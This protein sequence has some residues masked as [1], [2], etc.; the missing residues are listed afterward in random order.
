MINCN[1][2]VQSAI[3]Y[4]SPSGVIR[5]GEKVRVKMEFMFRAEYI[6]KG[7]LFIFREGCLKGFG[8]IVDVFDD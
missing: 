1:T 8:K 5:G 3:I 2:I 6:E 7:D 4:D